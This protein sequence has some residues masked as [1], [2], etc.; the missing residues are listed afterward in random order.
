MKYLFS[1]FF[2]PSPPPKKRRRCWFTANVI[3][4]LENKPIYYKLTY[5][6]TNVRSSALL[7]FVNDLL[8]EYLTQLPIE[9]SLPNI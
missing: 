2:H 3:L 6:L 7:R 1:D 4:P 9:I 5:S 8:L